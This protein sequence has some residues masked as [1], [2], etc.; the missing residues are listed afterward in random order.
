MLPGEC[1]RGDSA[2]A[3]EAHLHALLVRARLRT[4][5][6]ARR[7]RP[8]PSNTASSDDG[9]VRNDHSRATKMRDFTDA[10]SRLAPIS[11][12]DRA[13]RDPSSAAVR[14]AWPSATTWP[15]SA[16]GSSSSMQTNGP[17]IRGGPDGTRCAS[18]RPAY[19][20][21]LPGLEFPGPQSR[22]PTKDEMA[23][24]LEAYAARFD[25][26]VR[27][28]SGSRRSPRSTPIS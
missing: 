21:D 9:M 12:H 2:V 16:G 5:T 27:N 6:R 15:N 3:T 17:A 22:C 24:Y 7:R 28:V 20:N 4:P 8:S 13:G 23:D 10:G 14:P 1:R 25:L 19:L 26:P 18:S 11:S